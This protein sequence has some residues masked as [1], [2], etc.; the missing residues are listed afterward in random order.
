MK[1][2]TGIMGTMNFQRKRED[3]SV[4]KV[5]RFLAICTT[6][7]LAASAITLAQVKP[8]ESAIQSVQVVNTPNVNVA[9]TPS[10]HVTNTPSVNVANTPTVTLEAGASV[11]V[12]TPL[13][14][15]GNPTPLAVLDAV[16]P[17][18]DFCPILFSGSFVGSCDF[19]PIPSGKRLVIQEFDAQGTIETGLKPTSIAIVTSLLQHA[20]TATFMGTL[21]GF[22]NFA[23]HQETHLYVAPTVAPAC[24]VVLTGNSSQVYDCELSGF[25]VDVPAGGSGAA[26]PAQHPQRPRNPLL[27]RQPNNTGR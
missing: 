12:T 24:V 8:P 16:Q 6:T 2:H 11:N 10:V 25:L 1:L 5:L 27:G 17:Y 7:I 4:K 21:F 18:E 20:F 22:D 9:N 14:G 19:L 3:R 13:D 15:E 26:A 23:T